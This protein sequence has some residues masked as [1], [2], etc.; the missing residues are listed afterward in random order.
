MS[1][2]IPDVAKPAL[3]SMKRLKELPKNSPQAKAEAR[4]LTQRLKT[5]YKNN[6]KWFLVLAAAVVGAGGAYAKRNAI[7]ARYA[8]RYGTINSKVNATSKASIMNWVTQAKATVTQRAGSAYSGAVS[9]LA[10]AKARTTKRVGKVY[11]TIR[12]TNY[13]EIPGPY[14]NNYRF[15]S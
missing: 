7:A 5:L 3:K 14:K 12:G 4:A 11:R 2:R 6:K 1:S 8:A 13:S 15:P 10:N 9:R